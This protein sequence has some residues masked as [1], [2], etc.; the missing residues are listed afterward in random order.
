MKQRNIRLALFMISLIIGT[1]ISA[2]SIEIT[3]LILNFKGVMANDS[4]VVAYADY[5]SIVIST[6]NEQSWRQKRVFTGGEI[7]TVIQQKS[8]LIACND[9]GGIA[10]SNDKG[11]NWNIQKQLDDSIL[12]F[13]PF[14]EGYLVRCKNSVLI[15]DSTFSVIQTFALESPAIRKIP[16]AYSSFQ[17][18]YRKSI[19]GYND[20]CIIEIDSA[21]LIILDAQLRIIDTMNLKD[22]QVSGKYLTGYV[23]ATDSQYMYMKFCYADGNR[24][25]YSIYRMNN[26]F[27]IEKVLDSLSIFDY[28][29]VNDG[30]IIVMKSRDSKY[31]DSTTLSGNAIS[32]YFNGFTIANGKEYIFGDRKILQTMDQ[33]TNELKVISEYSN[34]TLNKFPDYL[35]NNTFLFHSFG[36]H[37]YKTTDNGITF[38]PT[39]DKT[40]AKFQPNFHKYTINRTY[41]DALKNTLYLFGDPYVT[42]YGFMWKSTDQ[43]RTF[44]SIAMDASFRQSVLYFRN[45]FTQGGIQKRDDEFIMSEGFNTGKNK[46]IWSS[47]VTIKENGKLVQRIMDSTMIFTNVYSPRVNSYL[48]HACGVFDSLSTIL[49]TNDAGKTWQ[50][51]HQYSINETIG[52]IV[53]V[54]MNGRNF[55]ILTHYDY[56]KPDYRKGMYLDVV[57]KETMQFTRIAQWGSETDKEYGMYGV[58]ITSYKDTTYIAFQD[59]V[60]VT[61]NLYD[62][63]RWNYHVLPE[64][65]RMIKPKRFGDVFFC[66]Y[67]DNTTPYGIGLSWVKLT[68]PIISHVEEET[69]SANGYLYAYPP[70]PNP[71]KNFVT[72]EIVWDAQYSE[73][74]IM[75]SI[76][77][78]KGIKVKTKDQLFIEQTSSNKGKVHWNCSGFEPGV[79]LM[80]IQHPLKSITVKCMVIP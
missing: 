41:Y 72:T 56:S 58:H 76:Y 36:P 80:S 8:T 59:T 25:M 65:G 78:Q 46:D 61:Q 35:S 60:F 24:N 69:S 44:D 20:H 11:E 14:N 70:S 67:T 47:L 6:D 31:I 51:I 5:G 33:K 45:A 15:L 32:T 4:I 79:Y 57:D 49:Y 54:S 77:N 73:E 63:K 64:N 34:I 1:A 68:D 66:N 50:T 12:A 62:K 30:K 74:D 13:I 38:L 18:N 55:W 27:D 2:R 23:L 17:P 37:F 10:S 40:D 19:T 53:D 3:P 43:G 21:K 75:V 16:L 26:K 48:V 7:I 22:H 28:Y 9:R 71:A 39:I 42:N 52:D 29:Q